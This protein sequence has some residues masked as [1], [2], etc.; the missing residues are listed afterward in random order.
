M[1]GSNLDGLPQVRAGDTVIVSK[2]NGTQEVGA[3]GVQIIGEVRAPSIYALEDVTDMVGMLLLAGG[4]ME[5][6]KLDK[7]RLVR[8]D[9]SGVTVSREYNVQSYLERGVSSQN[10]ECQAGDTIYVPRK[11]GTVGRF[12]R[13]VSIGLGIVASGLAI[14]NAV[15]H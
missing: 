5:T 8:T 13:N 4:P 3:D 7:V 11:L 6:S 12:L 9:A 1:N 2:R 15:R 14:N 10:P